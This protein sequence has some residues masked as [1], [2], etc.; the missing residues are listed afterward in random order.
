LLFVDNTP[1]HVSYDAM[2]SMPLTKNEDVC[3][4]SLSPHDDFV[5]D[6]SIV[7]P[8]MTHIDIPK[9]NEEMVGKSI[10]NNALLAMQ[11]PPLETLVDTIM[12][13][14]AIV[15]VDLVSSLLVFIGS[16]V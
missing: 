11:I 12:S 1:L 16:S 8:L 9:S 13:S 2:P 14:L 3:M 7:L 4:D 6:T 10:P 5:L 15:A